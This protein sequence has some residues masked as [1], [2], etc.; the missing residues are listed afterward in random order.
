MVA[1]KG[2]SNDEGAPGAPQFV[3]LEPVRPPGRPE[4]FI[5]IPPAYQGQKLGCTYT[6]ASDLK[7]PLEWKGPADGPE[8]G[9]KF[10]DT[11]FRGPPALSQELL[12]PFVG[13]TRAVHLGA[14]NPPYELME[15]EPAAPPVLSS[16]AT[17]AAA[18][19][20]AAA[21]ATASS[22]APS[23]RSNKAPKGPP[24]SARGK[25][26]AQLGPPEEP[27]YSLQSRKRPPNLIPPD[28]PPQ[29]A[30]SL[31]SV[32]ASKG[33]PE[34]SVPPS[35]GPLGA[36]P[37]VGG[38]LQQELFAKYGEKIL[39]YT[40]LDVG[41]PTSAAGSNGGACCNPSGA[42]APAGAPVVSP[43]GS[44]GGAPGG[45][46]GSPPLASPRTGAPLL[47]PTGAPVSSP[48]GSLASPGGPAESPVAP[49]SSTGAPSVGQGAW[50]AVQIDD[51]VPDGGPTGAPVFPV[52]KDP[53]EMWGPL[54]A[55]GILKAFRGPLAAGG[56][57]PPVIEALTGRKEVLL[58]LSPSLVSCYCLKGLWASVKLKANS[59][60]AADAADAAAGGEREQEGVQ[61]GGPLRSVGGPFEQMLG[62]RP[63]LLA[64]AQEG[65]TPSVSLLNRQSGGGPLQQLAG[66][67]GELFA[68]FGEAEKVGPP[69]PPPHLGTLEGPQLPCEQFLTDFSGALPLNSPQHPLNKEEEQQRAAAAA[70]A[71]AAAPPQITREKEGGPIIVQRPFA[72]LLQHLLGG[73]APLPAEMDREE[74]E[75]PTTPGSGEDAPVGEIL[76]SEVHP[77]A[78][79]GGVAA[80]T[81]TA[82]AASAAAA[83]AAEQEVGSPR[84]KDS[85]NS[86]GNADTP[87]SGGAAAAAVARRGSGSHIAQQNK[88][89][90]IQEALK[91]WGVPWATGGPPPVPPEG[92]RLEG[93]P[94]VH[95][96]KMVDALAALDEAPLQELYDYQQGPLALQ[97]P[98]RAS[99][100]LLNIPKRRLFPPAAPAAAATTTT[101]AAA[102]PSPTSNHVAAGEAGE[103]AATNKKRLLNFFRPHTLILSLQGTPSLLNNPQQG[104]PIK[105]TGGPP[106]DNEG[107]LQQLQQQQLQQQK[108]QEMQQQQ[109][110]QKQRED[111]ACHLLNLDTVI[112]QWAAK[113]PQVSAWLVAAAAAATSVS[114]EHGAATDAAGGIIPGTAAAAAAA[115]FAAAA[116]MLMGPERVNTLATGWGA[117]HGSRALAATS[118]G[119]LLQQMKGALLA[120]DVGLPRLGADRGPPQMLRLAR[121]LSSLLLHGEKG[122]PVSC[123]LELGAGTFAFLVILR[124]PA[125]AAPFTVS[126]RRPLLQLQ[127]LQQQAEAAQQQQQQQQS[128][129]KGPSSES[130]GAAASLPKDAAGAPQAILPQ[131]PLEVPCTHLSL[132]SFLAGPPLSFCVQQYP[133]VGPERGPPG[134][135]SIWYKAEVEALWS[136][137][138]GPPY[139]LLMLQVP[140]AGLGP[141]LRLSLTPLGPPVSVSAAGGPQALK[142]AT[143]QDPKQQRSVAVNLGASDLRSLPLLPFLKVPLMDPCLQQQQ[144]IQQ[145]QQQQPQYYIGRYLLLLEAA[146]PTPSRA[147]H[148]SLSVAMPPQGPPG[149]PEGPLGPPGA[150]GLPGLDASTKDAAGG[151]PL[152][153]TSLSPQR[154]LCMQPLPLTFKALWQGT[155]LGGPQG[156]PELLD[157]VGGPYGEA[158]LLCNHRLVVRGPQA[159]RL[160]LSLTAEGAPPGALLCAKLL[161]L[162]KR[163]APD[164]AR[165]KRLGEDNSHA[166][167]DPQHD[168]SPTAAAGA[169]GTSSK[170]TSKAS[171]GAAAEADDGLTG[172]EDMLQRPEEVLLLQQEAPSCCIFAD[173]HLLPGALYVLRAHY[174]EEAPPEPP[175]PRSTTESYYCRSSSSNSNR[176]T[177]SNSGNDSN[178][179]SSS[180]SSSTL[181]WVLEATGS[182]E[183]AVGPDITKDEIAA[184]WKEPTYPGR[185]QQAVLSRRLYLQGPPGALL[186]GPLLG[187]S[188][189]SSADT[190]GV[191]NPLSLQHL[192]QLVYWK[193]NLTIVQFVQA[194]KAEAQQQQQQEEQQDQQQQE[195]QDQQ[196]QQQESWRQDDIFGV[197]SFSDSKRLPPWWGP[198]SIECSPRYPLWG[199][200]DIEIE[201]GE[202]PFELT[203]QIFCSSKL[204]TEGPLGLLIGGPDALEK[205]YTECVGPA[206]AAAGGGPMTP[207]QI[208]AALEKGAAG[209][210]QKSR[211]EEVG[212]PRGG[213]NNKKNQGG[214]D[215][216]PRG[217][218]E[219][220]R[221]PAASGGRGPLS[222]GGKD[223]AR[224]DRGQSIVSSEGAPTAPV[225]AP[226]LLKGPLQ[227]E[228][229]THPELKRFVASIAGESATRIVGPP[230]TWGSQMGAPLSL[231]CGAPQAKEG[232][233]WGPLIEEETATD[234]LTDALEETT[235]CI[236]NM[237]AM[238]QQ[239]EEQQE[240]QQ[241]QQHEGVEEDEGGPPPPQAP[242]SP[243]LRVRGPQK[244]TREALRLLQLKRQE[245]LSAAAE[246]MTEEAAKD[247]K[248]DTLEKVLQ[249]M[250]QAKLR[251]PHKQTEEKLQNTLALLKATQRTFWRGLAV[252][253][254]AAAAVLQQRRRI[255]VVL[256]SDKKEKM[257]ILL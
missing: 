257:I 256:R 147:V 146:L 208:A 166:T 38:G 176:S 111:T 165:D 81:A 67:P 214:L 36:P 27:S 107:S 150:E 35:G 194:L 253:A 187:G 230:I 48:G 223:E 70:A 207:Q 182:G 133:I 216:K 144:Q 63:F 7:G 167:L 242:V 174:Y 39:P 123:L 203:Q 164:A 85:S 233:C 231:S 108:K 2:P 95:W 120:E 156:P 170:T 49:D 58:P 46:S 89:A 152:S 97:Y 178:S 212:G 19:A 188:V 200:P 102:A 32:G 239:Q 69:R 190:P 224:R 71:A 55:K 44:N 76:T 238:L 98:L 151:P 155:P 125:A 121:G 11:S 135:H 179:S 206:L 236:G 131:G 103:T 5:E 75:G 57:P 149:A 13:W 10:V 100:C 118:A 116:Q 199:A 250:Q 129:R 33:P 86:G 84:G 9:P 137:F 157:L 132:E 228:L 128:K 148:C 180:S 52:S 65:D 17:A 159:A 12:G 134:C 83:P 60:A 8:G 248:I 122:A 195:Q 172:K 51:I 177:S 217:P 45:S 153:P 232:P 186:R 222:K 160:S 237:R 191:P 119:L 185:S 117:P 92:L 40:C 101:A 91:T 254:A 31:K 78:P 4:G 201:G 196:E 229:Y 59:A 61:R 241:Q 80:A 127:Q 23:K 22:S 72:V 24:N 243:L 227:P 138:W 106:A 124:A 171:K 226:Q 56:G 189:S 142:G 169:A 198:P 235:A 112:P 246:I 220:G 74:P 73:G 126:W 181:N 53:R 50:R 79:G 244:E 225:A 183:V 105:E 94:W 20:A 47:S 30:S 37:P 145:Q 3:P 136:C 66:A 143:S 221:A 161:Q 173:V 96:Q 215:K 139:L 115:E 211:E 77:G 158:I 163:G 205:L 16:E 21:D 218:P 15:F 209:A 43:G 113:T 251:G 130:S 28:G 252:A 82:A 14:P 197:R 202:G 68:A 175:S 93:G 140:H 247:I 154:P 192:L 141:L 204:L 90:V 240:Q 109:Q 114:A 25:D 193:L 104:A 1:P 26:A 162:V 88:A 6:A 99:V 62:W 213:G 34:P 184:A 234:D 18:A 168:G 110:Q 210:P 245:V 54:L 219:K 42:G 255:V 41:P 249:Q 29:G 64:A 87:R